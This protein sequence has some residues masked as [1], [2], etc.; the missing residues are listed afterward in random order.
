M[1][2]F[3]IIAALFAGQAAAGPTTAVDMPTALGVLGGVYLVG[4]LVA[5]L[6]EKMLDRMPTMRNGRNG[7]GRQLTPRPCPIS[8]N[9]ALQSHWEAVAEQTIEQTKVLRAI[10]DTL[11]NQSADHKI[12]GML[13]ERIDRRGDG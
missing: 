12:Q 3:S 13:L 2:F 1:H 7:S 5:P 8:D 9:A 11:Q 6:V 4:K 10:H